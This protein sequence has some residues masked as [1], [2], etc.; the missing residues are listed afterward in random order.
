M[1][2]DIA[3]RA[4]NPYLEYYNLKDHAM[5]LPNKILFFHIPKTAGQSLAETLSSLFP[6]EETIFNQEQI[7]LDTI[8]SNRFISG[9]GLWKNYIEKVAKYDIYTFTFLRHPWERYKSSLAHYERDSNL[10][11]DTDHCYLRGFTKLSPF[12]NYT[13]EDHFESSMSAISSSFDFIGIVEKFELSLQELFKQ[14]G[15]PLKYVNSPKLNQ[16]PRAQ[17]ITQHLDQETFFEK[18]KYDILLYEHFKKNLTSSTNKTPGTEL[19]LKP[20]TKVQWCVAD[21][22]YGSNFWQR[23]SISYPVISREEKNE[24]GHLTNQWRWTGPHNTS[25]MFFNLVEDFYD[26]NLTVI[27]II[28]PNLPNQ[29][30][31]KIN[32]QILAVSV[33]PMKGYF[34]FS[35]SSYLHGTFCLEIIVPTT[36][37]MSE[38]NPEIDDERSVGIAISQISIIPTKA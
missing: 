24:L 33:K 8:D 28:P 19:I 6:Y 2:L 10:D 34:L 26:I 7:N 30:T 29:I 17:N 3:L 15:V 11:R 38:L 16:K 31:L 22:L 20:Q 12:P 32:S 14:I 25:R 5:N 13:L 35:T 23:E 37:A 36:T 4:P 27:N 1:I 9:H 21:P 18:N